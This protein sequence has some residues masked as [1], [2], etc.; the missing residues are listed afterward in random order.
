MTQHSATNSPTPVPVPLTTP[1]RRRP[2]TA[3]YWLGAVVAVLATLGALAWGISTFLGWQTH[4]EDFARLTPPGM[5]SVSVS[6]PDTRYLYLEHDRSTA[7]PSVPTVTV[8][9]PSG[10]EVPSTAYRAQ[11]RYDVPDEADRIGDAV[12]TFEADEP[13]TYLVTVGDTDQGT[14]VAVG[15]DLLR[16]WGLQVV[17]SVALLLGGLFVGLTLV[18]VTA[19]RRTGATP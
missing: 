5:V 8:T 12:L 3:G 1:A 2:S 4:V 16:G 17:G 9:G 7:V 10:T 11:L 6:D 18:V 19:A 13:G 14:T 15:D